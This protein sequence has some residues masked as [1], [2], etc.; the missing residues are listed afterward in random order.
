MIIRSTFPQVYKLI[1]SKSGNPRWFVSA[2]S[3]KWELN[4]RPTFGNEKEALDEARQIEASIKQRGAQPTIPKDKLSDVAAYEK[5][6]KRLAPFNKTPEDAIEHYVKFRGDEILRQAMPTVAQLVDRWEAYKFLDTTLDEQYRN[7]IKLHCRFIKRKW[8]DNRADE[9]RKNDIETILKQHPVT[10]NTRKKYLT[11]VRM[12]F[13]WVLAE[14][15]GYIVTNPAI[16]IKFRPDKFEKKFYQ[17]EIL[18]EF[19]RQLAEK[20]PQL[21]GYY[22]VLLFAGLRPSEGARIKWKHFNFSTNELHVVNGKTDARHIL[23]EPV[24]IEWAK[25]HRKHSPKDALFVPE[26]NL[27]NLEREARG[28]VKDDWIANGLR[29]TFATFYNSLKK[30]YHVVAWYM[31]NSTAMIKK[32]YAQTISSEQLNQFWNLTPEKVITEPP[33]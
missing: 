7:E 15:R 1:D 12:F 32:H 25:W 4:K 6:I 20:Y 23:L 14:D 31:G 22:S 10:N 11:F 26:K 19:F 3:K 5:L 30:D 2:R 24:A 33:K 18:K 27:F 29:H 21:I 13:K 8:G 17:M 28:L 9:I 16:G